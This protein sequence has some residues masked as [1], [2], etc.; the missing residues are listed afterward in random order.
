MC[1]EVADCGVVWTPVSKRISAAFAGLRKLSLVVPPRF[2][3][4]QYFGSRRRG[5][6]FFTLN[7]SGRE[8]QAGRYWRYR[9]HKGPKHALPAAHRPKLDRNFEIIISESL[10]L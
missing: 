4:E 5:K 2:L 10:V 9:F 7:F 8:L 3:A 6:M 1:L